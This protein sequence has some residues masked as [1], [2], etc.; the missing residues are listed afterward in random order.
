MSTST[1]NHYHAFIITK[2]RCL[3]LWVIN[4][5]K[6]N[7]RIHHSFVANAF[8]RIIFHRWTFT[9]N[10]VYRI[11]T[12]ASTPRANLMLELASRWYVDLNGLIEIR[13]QLLISK[14]LTR[15]CSFSLRFVVYVRTCFVV[16]SVKFLVLIRQVI[17]CNSLVIFETQWGPV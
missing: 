4:H 10:V 8:G 15:S 3:H 2:S 16:V 12:F 5:L 14:L 11:H 7:V 1:V 6:F 9:V 13:S 17:L